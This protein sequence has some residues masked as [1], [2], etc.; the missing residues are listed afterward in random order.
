MVLKGCCVSLFLFRKKYINVDTVSNLA[1]F[2][3]AKSQSAQSWACILE[4]D[5]DDPI[6]FLN[7]L[8]TGTPGEEQAVGR[9]ELQLT[10]ACPSWRSKLV[11][12][13]EAGAEWLLLEL[14]KTA[15]S[16]LSADPVGF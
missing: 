1:A 11:A 9:T 13:V 5:R 3:I 14:E 8:P 12:G 4:D 2:C 6:W 10:P 16:R 15:V 7:R